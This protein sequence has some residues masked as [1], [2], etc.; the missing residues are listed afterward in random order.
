MKW[1][2]FR[3]LTKVRTQVKPTCFVREDRLEILSLILA[4]R[5]TVEPWRPELLFG[6]NRAIAVVL[7]SYELYRRQW[8][9]NVAVR[10]CTC[11]QWVMGSI[12]TGS[13]SR[14]N[15][16]EVV[17]TYVS[18]SPSSMAWYWSKDGDFFSAGKVTAVLVES[19]GSL[20]PGDDLKSPAGWLP[21]HRDQIRAQRS[22]T[23]L[24]FYRRQTVRQQMIY[25]YS[26]HNVYAVQTYRA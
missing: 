24:P 12:L 17:H 19:N 7:S 25:I 3:V 11:N 9:T 21:V 1:N 15:L 23:S 18:L 10:L 8:R 6:D 16:G 13:K 14:N 22:V 4:C 20:P 5:T 26:I 2:N